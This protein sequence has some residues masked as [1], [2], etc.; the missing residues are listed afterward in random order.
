MTSAMLYVH[1]PFCHAKCAYCDF[2]ST[3]RSEWMESW[4]EAV[5]QERDERCPEE[6]AP[7]TVYLGGGT[8]SS[9]PLPLLVRLIRGLHL[10][11]RLE[12]FTIE[13]NPED[14]TPEW[15]AGI[16]ELGVDRVSMGIQ[17]LDDEQL[18]FIGRRHT[19]A[20]AVEAVRTLREGGIDN[21]SLDL[22]YGL[23]GQ[24]VES[25]RRSLDMLLDLRPEHLSAYLLSYEPQ[26]RLGVMLSKG[27]VKEAA[28]ETVAEMYGYLCEATR[29]AGYE[30]YE[31]SNFAL[32]GCRAVHNSGY[33]NETPYIGLG[34]GAHSFFNGAR[35]YNP[36]NLHEYLKKGGRGVHVVEEEDENNRFNDLLM[37]SLRTSTGI[38]PESVSHQFGSHIRLAFESDY[39]RLLSV[40]DLTRT[41]S[42]SLRIPEE[43]WLLSNQIIL[44][45]IIV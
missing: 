31:I 29:R 19:A 2:Y 17:S 6:F 9:L 16:I 40:G 25:W 4:V 43:R 33:W 18:R 5:L 3:P 30:H 26:T 14:V 41:P 20:E 10:P 28:E 21:L 8:P 13:A 12:E 42:G 32:A 22:I 27:K 23:P 36:S 15:V 34:P 44:K 1:V 24:S 37:T 35:G 45:M 39:P 7:S 11:E 38:D